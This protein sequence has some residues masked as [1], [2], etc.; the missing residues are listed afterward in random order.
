MWQES[1]A[2]SCKGARL[3]Q[4]RTNSSI[5]RSYRRIKRDHDWVG[6]K[7]HR[8]RPEVLLADFGECRTRRTALDLSHVRLTPIKHEIIRRT[9]IAL[10][11]DESLIDRNGNL[12]DRDVAHGRAR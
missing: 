1:V 11:R 4:V 2:K 12:R 7:K 5:V 6:W 3:N 9:L 8:Y 10:H